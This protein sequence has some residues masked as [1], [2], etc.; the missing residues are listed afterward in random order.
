MHFSGLHQ[1]DLSLRPA[2][3]RPADTIG[4]QGTSV[5]GY[6]RADSGS[7]SNT[8]HDTRSWF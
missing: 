1:Q 2:G 7:C 8:C 3:Q 4:G 6:D 5:I